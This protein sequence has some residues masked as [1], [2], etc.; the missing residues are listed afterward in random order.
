MKIFETIT[1]EVL[2]NPSQEA[3]VVGSFPH[4]HEAINYVETFPEA[5]RDCLT[6]VETVV[7]K[8]VR[9]RWK[10]GKRYDLRH[11]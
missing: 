10:G 4:Q 2:R 11:S 3:L 6:V 8:S 1:Y 7:T 5:L 9:V